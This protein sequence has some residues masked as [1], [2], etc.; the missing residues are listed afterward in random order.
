MKSYF[1]SNWNEFNSIERKSRNVISGTVEWLFIAFMLQLINLHLY[2][3][4]S[5]AIVVVE[6]QNLA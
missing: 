1:N 6:F 4:D 5:I 2:I 3:Y